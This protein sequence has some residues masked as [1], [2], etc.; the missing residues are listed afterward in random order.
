MELRYSL[1]T[2]RQEVLSNNDEMDPHK[3][4]IFNLLSV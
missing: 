3:M 2:P 4:Q 1:A